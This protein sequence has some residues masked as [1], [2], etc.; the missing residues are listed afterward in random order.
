MKLRSILRVLSLL[1]FVSAC[2]SGYIYYNYLEK[3]AYQEA[4]RNALNRLQ[5][6]KKNLSAK[7]IP[8]HVF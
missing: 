6:T 2:I 4:E 3:Y 5:T 8:D 7:F 1:A